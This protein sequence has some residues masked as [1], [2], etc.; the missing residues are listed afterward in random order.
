MKNSRIL[1]IAAALVAASVTPKAIAQSCSA[2][3]AAFEDRFQTQ[4]N[5]PAAHRT[6]FR[7]ETDRVDDL[8]GYAE[9]VGDRA[10]LTAALPLSAAGLSLPGSTTHYLKSPEAPG[11]VVLAQ[12]NWWC[13]VQCLRMGGNIDDCSIMCS[14]KPVQQ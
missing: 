6:S 3:P 5:R 7:I 8:H 13:F 11:V 14:G 1:L 9:G 2:K 4:V 12:F 10:V